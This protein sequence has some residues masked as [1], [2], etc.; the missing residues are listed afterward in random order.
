MRE[1]TILKKRLG[2]AD[3]TVNQ[4]LTVQKGLKNA[5][6]KKGDKHE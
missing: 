1:N 6:R 3:A 2:A 5:T 4:Q